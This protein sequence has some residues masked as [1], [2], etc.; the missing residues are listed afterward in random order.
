MTISTPLAIVTVVAVFVLGLVALVR[1]PSGDI[2]KIIQALTR[3][4]GK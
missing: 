3:W 4:F 2:A 1:A